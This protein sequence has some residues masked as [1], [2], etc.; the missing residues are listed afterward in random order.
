MLEGIGFKMSNADSSLFV[1]D[2]SASKVVILIYVD[3]LIVT[4]DSLTEI[5]RLKGLLHRKFAIKDLGTLKYFLGI[6]IASS[7]KGLLLNQR[8]YILDLLQELKMLE[9]KPVAT[10]I[11]CK[12][13]L[14]LDGDL[15]TNVGLHQ[16]LVGNLIY[17][18]ITRPDI[19]H[20]VSLVS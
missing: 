8:K 2:S 6:E 7:S 1:R 13:K 16:R 14:G 11:A 19:M 12:E 15:L 4:G 3:D 5:Q 10:P 20:D 17:L 9:A 18:T